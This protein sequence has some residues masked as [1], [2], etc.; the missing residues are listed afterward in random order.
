MIARIM[1]ENQY[2]IDEAH[3]GE[4]DRLDDEMVAAMDGD[5]A[6]RFA[7]ALTDL[8]A[9]VRQYGQVVPNEELVPSDVMIPAP[10][11]SLAEAHAL[12]HQAPVAEGGAG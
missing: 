4:I 12:P 8:I 7:A 1:T 11:M 5:D 9:H 10:D 3:T 6:G 2:R